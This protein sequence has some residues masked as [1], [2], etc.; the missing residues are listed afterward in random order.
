MPSYRIETPGHCYSAIVE[1]GIIG[2]AAQHLPAKRGKVFVV[3]TEDVWRHQGETLDHGLRGVAYEVLHLP[4]GEDKKRLAP[5]E[6]MAEEMVRR[7]ADRSSMVIAFGGGI[8]NDMG[9]FLA[10][11]F[12]RGIPVVQVPTTLL[13]QV[14]ASIGGKTGVN[15][16][17]GK[18]LIGS[19]HQP[20]TVLIDPAVLQ[21][22]PER[23]YRSGLYE[24]IKAGVIR[25]PRLFEYL[26]LNSREVLDR[27]PD[28]VDYII[29][30]SVRMKAEVV[31]SDEREGDMRR[32]LN[33][34]HTFGHA[35]ESE[36]GYTR[37]LHGE[38]VEWG[39]RAAVYLSELTGNLSAEDSVEILETLELYG[40][41]PPLEGISAENLLG[42]LVHDK[43]TVQGKV[44]FVLATRIGEVIVQSG[45]DEKLVLE[46]IKS[47]L[48]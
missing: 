43:K 12:M 8:V 10:A 9:G 3:T 4:G 46:A 11:I 45:I 2:Q 35:L 34:G 21:S 30:E 25:E 33:F 32:I 1:R 14:D 26:A 17:S 13:A 31:S 23:E 15:L 47:A 19:F 20:L 38:A 22:L 6:E 44:H 18:N 36:T 16:V 24:I 42:R 29:A 39:M 40:P 41:I 37:F 5:V 28:A 27:H 7:G 48:P